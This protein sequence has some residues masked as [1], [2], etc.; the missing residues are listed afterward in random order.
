MHCMVNERPGVSAWQA[1]Q[2]RHRVDVY[3]NETDE[4]ERRVWRIFVQRRLPETMH[5]DCRVAC[6]VMWKQAYTGDPWRVAAA[7]DE[8]CCL[9]LPSLN[10][11]EW[12]VERYVDVFQADVEQPL[13]VH[14]AAVWW[15]DE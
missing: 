13:Q 8:Q 15:R 10:D 1:L 3:D 6:L 11:E 2:I 4:G 5:A 14:V 7:D 12:S 9:V